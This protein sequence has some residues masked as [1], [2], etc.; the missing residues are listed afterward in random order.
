MA[1][2]ES[3]FAMN[4]GVPDGR[5]PAGA[6]W[7]RLAGLPAAFP[8]AADPARD[9]C[10][11]LWVSPVL[12]LRGADMLAVHE[13]ARP[14]FE[15]H[16]FDL[17]ATFSMINERTLGG[18]LTVAYD[19]HDPHEAA[20]ARACHDEVFGRMFDA[21][22]IPYRVGN[23]AMG[24]LDPGSDSYWRTVARIIRGRSIRWARSRLVATSRRAPAADSEF[25]AD[26]VRRRTEPRDSSR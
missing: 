6:Y 21:G 17:F 19:K 7:R 12:P 3:L 4:R 13:L 23:H 16:G 1:L 2:G 25:G 18:V 9:G 24:R 5:F 10:G 22:Y 26:S 11:L 15:R 14:S 8:E 20:R